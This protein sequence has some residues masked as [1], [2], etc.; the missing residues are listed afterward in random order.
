MNLDLN[1][2]DLLLSAHPEGPDPSE[3]EEEPGYYPMLVTAE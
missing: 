3:E 1:L 2:D